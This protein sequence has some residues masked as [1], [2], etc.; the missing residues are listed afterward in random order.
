[1]GLGAAAVSV[2]SAYAGIRPHP[3]DTYQRDGAPS[4][5]S[6]VVEKSRRAVHT[7]DC[8]LLDKKRPT[9]CPGGVNR[10]VACEARALNGD[11]ATDLS[12]GTA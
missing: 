12:Q 7:N 3:Q 4:T 6:I 1:M 9:S 11:D 8:V 10:K 2:K 5:G